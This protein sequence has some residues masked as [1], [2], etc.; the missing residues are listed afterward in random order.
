MRHNSAASVLLAGCLTALVA[1]GFLLASISGGFGYDRYVLDKPV[2]TFVA[3]QFAAGLIYLLTL[4]LL[5][6]RGASRAILL[7]VFAAGLLMRLSQFGAT[8]ILETDHYRYLWDGAVTAQGLSPYTHAP[9][10]VRSAFFDGPEIQRLADRA[11]GVLDRINHPKL[12]TIYPPTA[13]AAFALA[14]LID[15]FSLDGLRATWLA[16]DLLIA[17]L[18]LLTLRRVGSS[19]TALSLAVYWLNP[20]LIKEVFNSGHME[21]VLIAAALGAL[22][23]AVSKRTVASMFLL[24]LAAGAKLWPILWLP[25]LLRAHAT[26]ALRLALALAVFAVTLG[27][28]AAPVLLSGLDDTSGFVAYAR[29]WQMNDSAYLL[30]H[31]AFLLITPTHAPL[32]ARATVGLLLLLILALALRRRPDSPQALIGGLLAVTA[33]LFLLSPTQ[34]PWYYTW[35]LPLLALRPMR[36]LLALTVTL[37]LYYLRFPLDARDEAFLFDYVIVWIEF[38]PIWLLLAFD[39]LKPRPHPAG[40]TA[41]PTP[42]GESLAPGTGLRVAVVI[43]ALNEERA[44]PQVLEAIPPWVTQ[45]IV[46]DNGST[47]ATASLAQRAGAT[48]VHEPKRGYGAACLA[49]LAALD[50]PDVVVFMDGDFSDHPQEMVQLV[51]PIARDEADLVIG[52][53]VLGSAEPGALTPQQRFGNAL[54][55]ALIRRF[56][57]VRYTDLG[58]F[59]AIRYASL[60]RLNMNDRDFGWTVQMQVRAAKL[61][62]RAIETP[63][64]YRRRIGKSK[65]S[66]TL[67]GVFLAGTKILSTIFQERFLSPAKPVLSATP[68][69]PRVRSDPACERLIIFAR[70]PT[71]GRAKTRLIPLL[72]PKGAA[73]LH[74]QLVRITAHTARRLRS[75]RSVDIELRYT[76]AAQRDMERLFGKDLLYQEQA[77][78][79][80]GQRLQLAAR[81]AIGHGFHKVVLVGTDCPLLDAPRLEQAFQALD[82][83]DVVLG[84]ALDGGYYLLGVKAD[85]PALFTDIPWGGPEVLART[86]DAVAQLR[87][88]HALLPALPDVDLPE[89][90]R[91]WASAR[92]TP[93]EARPGLSVIIPARNEQDHLAAT[94][95]SVLTASDLQ[96]IVVDGQSDDRTPDIAR[97]FS[98]DLI[99]SA[100]S[101]GRQLNLGASLARAPRLLF[102]HADTHLPHGFAGVVDRTLAQPGV[103]AGAFELRIDAR[104]LFPREI[105]HAV[106]LRSRLLGQPYGDQAIFMSR[107]TYLA[108]EGFPDLPRMEDFAMLPRLKALGR[109]R[110]ASDFVMTSARRWQSRGWLR[111]TLHHQLL[112]LQHLLTRPPK[113]SPSG[114]GT[115]Y[116]E[117]TNRPPLPNPAPPESGTH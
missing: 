32:A 89:D 53:R 12:R 40:L 59:R 106:S 81:D 56:F 54:A 71:P 17:G 80:L 36:S 76:G 4:Y 16:L 14:H 117:K 95:A 115:M 10:D 63:V 7:A 58:P 25:L 97:A 43:P 51:G 78:G 67:R 46:A 62:L 55:C 105:E 37:P 48:V 28:L 108:C 27:L 90:L 13:Q 98:L 45:V 34:F 65:I 52:S 50:R 3:L 18:V 23:A 44:L 5:R 82:Q 107:D 99:Q 60:I 49:G 77:P 110:I 104:G 20:L 19:S 87:L 11:D 26:K 47:D 93:P 83:H 102:L 74:Q 86:L 70:H 113:P 114:A 66:G 72:G 85:H 116:V 91:T 61:G 8:P 96:V 84:P 111:T 101:R 103:A 94:L 41:S 109:I 112:I 1:W 42:S 33:A 6:G 30:I 69:T 39:L 79:D 29:G 21:L 9:H 100:P 75:R 38:A 73:L 88:S 31:H 68:S 22:L 24:A 15:P 2:A 35:L 64:S 57:R 92:L